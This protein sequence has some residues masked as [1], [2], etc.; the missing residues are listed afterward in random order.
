LTR[1]LVVDD[2]EDN[3]N[4]FTVVL[5]YAG[6]KVDSYSDPLQVLKEFKP[7]YYDL[8]ILDYLMPGLNGFELYKRLRQADESIKVLILT[9]SQEPVHNSHKQ[10]GDMILKVARKPIIISKLLVEIDSIL[11]LERNKVVM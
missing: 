4:L 9:A 10:I 5:E 1:I 6:Y 7:S 2:D 3:L 11:R 8:V